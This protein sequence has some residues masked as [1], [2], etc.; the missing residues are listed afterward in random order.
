MIGISVNL[1]GSAFHQGERIVGNAT[2]PLIPEWVSGQAYT[3]GDV[4]QHGGQGWKALADVTSTTHPDNDKDNWV[5]FSLACSR[6]WFGAPTASH[7]SGV[8]TAV[9]LIGSSTSNLSGGVPLAVDNYVGFDRPYTDAAKV[10]L[11]GLAADDSVE[12]Q[13]IG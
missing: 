12:F 3:T 13:L 9:M 4:I 11:T 1:A 5:G 10:Y 6:I 8:N 2:L 7:T